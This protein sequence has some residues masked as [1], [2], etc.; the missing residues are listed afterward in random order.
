MCRST[1][2]KTIYIESRM[3]MHQ[4]QLG[5][6]ISYRLIRSIRICEVTV[7][8]ASLSGSEG[9]VSEKI[10]PRAL[11][12]GSTVKA[13]NLV[14]KTMKTRGAVLWSLA[15]TADR[16]TA[17]RTLRRPPPT[18]TMTST[19]PLAVR[20]GVRATRS[21][22]KTGQPSGHSMG[23]GRAGMSMGAGAQSNVGFARAL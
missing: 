2:E 12:C 10:A 4:E 23:D 21:S 6:F 3:A 17:P 7:T 9:L 14:Y 11:Y 5:A 18:S 1:C 16:T 13:K 19:L 20:V 8:R 22:S 15:A